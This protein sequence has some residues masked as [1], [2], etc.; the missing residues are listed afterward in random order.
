M[1]RLQKLDLVEILKKGQSRVIQLKGQVNLVELPGSLFSNFWHTQ[2]CSAAL[3]VLLISLVEQSKQWGRRQGTW[4]KAAELIS[5]EYGLA[6]SSF[7]KGKAELSTWGILT[8]QP[9]AMRAGARLG[10]YAI[11]LS[12]FD[13]KPEETQPVMKKIMRYVYSALPSGSAG[14]P[15]TAGRSQLLS[16]AFPHDSPLF[17]TYGA[18]SEQTAKHVVP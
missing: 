13:K 15:S 18:R 17:T 5:A 12:V 2:L 16:T 4:Y 9:S 11:D 10:L 6:R 1:S 3:A 7:E 8:W 14:C